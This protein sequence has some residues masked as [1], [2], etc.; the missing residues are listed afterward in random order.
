MG[1]AFLAG[2]SSLAVLGITL[3]DLRFFIFDKLYPPETIYS[4]LR[5]QLQKDP[6]RRRLFASDI[7]SLIGEQ[8]DSGYSRTF[9]YGPGDHNRFS[10]GILQFYA[11]KDQVVE[12]T[13]TS[14]SAA[15]G[16]HFSL[17]VDNQNVFEKTGIKEPVI[18][19]WL[20][21]APIKDLLRFDSPSSVDTEAE[22]KEKKKYIHTLRVDPFDL[23]PKESAMFEVLVL[24]RNQ[25]PDS[26]DQER[27]ADAR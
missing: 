16:R 2:L 6:E 15:I 19:D 10:Q 13:L 4:R 7:R 8:V 25:F 12:V 3:P 23:H 1:I 24:V 26:D 14:E 21:A 17:T 11:R 20:S 18:G 5:E 9:Y 22:K 27:V